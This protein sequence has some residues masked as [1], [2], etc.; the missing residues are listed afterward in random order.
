MRF[1]SQRGFTL[2]ELIIIVLVVM[3]SSIFFVSG[4]SNDVKEN[5]FSV[6][7]LYEIANSISL[8]NE[9]ILEYSYFKCISK[10]HKFSFYA[11]VSDYKDYTF[12]F[13]CKYYKRVYF[14]NRIYKTKIFV[15]DKLLELKTHKFKLWL[16]N[17]GDYEPFSKSVKLL[18]KQYSDL[19]KRLTVLH[20][21]R[22]KIIRKYGEGSDVKALDSDIKKLSALGWELTKVTKRFFAAIKF[23]KVQLDVAA[24]RQKALAGLRTFENEIDSAQ[25]TSSQSL[26]DIIANIDQAVRKLER[27]IN[28]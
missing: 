14:D 16:Y 22:A 15:E 8:N 6:R 26:D 17:V 24:T 1:L 18:R 12:S 19:A 23:K 25:T 20:E 7:L 9:K 13:S 21:G 4:C 27:A 28:Q 5:R 10:N 2:I 3:G 11:L